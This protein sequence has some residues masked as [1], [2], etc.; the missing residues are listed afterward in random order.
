MTHLVPTE[1][2]EKRIFLLRGRKVMLSSDL[3]DLYGVEPRALVQAVKRNLERFPDDF[4][5]QLENQEVRILKSQSVISSWGGLR[6]NP[7]AF[8]ELGIA[9]LSSIL[10]SR[11]AILVNIEI[12]RAFVHLREMM[13]THKDLAL[14]LEQ[15]EKKYDRQFKAVFDA[16]RELM[17]PPPPPPKRP[18]GFDLGK[19][20]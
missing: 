2:I 19:K 9:M 14:K 5:F 13:A 11:Q 18:I 17:T 1:R 3:A 15:L 7:Y 6:S 8:T 10:R 12:M 16:I 4:T 20:E